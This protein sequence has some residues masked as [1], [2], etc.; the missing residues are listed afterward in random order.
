[1]TISCEQVVGQD[2]Q[3]PRKERPSRVSRTA[4][5][6]DGGG[7]TDV[8]E[9]LNMATSDV[10]QESNVEELPLELDSIIFAQAPGGA[11]VADVTWNAGLA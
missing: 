9:T 3:Q 5:R 7:E 4:E 6:R 10:E 8:D 2:E 1:M 11:E